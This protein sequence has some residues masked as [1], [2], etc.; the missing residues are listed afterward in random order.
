MST[1]LVKQIL[2]GCDPS[3]WTPAADNKP[4][5]VAPEVPDRTAGT[6]G[7]ALSALKVLDRYEFRAAA[8]RDRVVQDINKDCVI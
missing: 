6:I 7:R 3:V 5:A 4:F 1:A 8:R 2:A